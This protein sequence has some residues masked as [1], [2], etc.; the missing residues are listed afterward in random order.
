M[1]W[2]EQNENISLRW[3]SGQIYRQIG[4]QTEEDDYND[5]RQEGERAED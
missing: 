3:Y 2:D 4:K 1:S 5:K